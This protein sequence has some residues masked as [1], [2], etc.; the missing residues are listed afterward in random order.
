MSTNENNIAESLPTCPETGLKVESYITDYFSDWAPKLP[1][2]WDVFDVRVSDEVDPY[3]KRSESILV[4]RIG[5]RN[6]VLRAS[7]MAAGVT[8]FP[9]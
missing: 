8:F 6:S 5:P 4:R 9:A 2:G 1:S 7:A 3:L